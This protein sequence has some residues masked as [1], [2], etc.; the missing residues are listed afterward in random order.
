MERLEYD[1]L[2]R[3]LTQKLASDPTTRSSKCRD[4]Y[5][6]GLLAAKSRTVM[7]TCM[8]GFLTIPVKG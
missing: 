3:L 6:E 7:T 8:K 1:A 2:Q 5:R 4:G